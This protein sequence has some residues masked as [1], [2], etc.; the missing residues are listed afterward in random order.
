MV[1]YPRTTNQQPTQTHAPCFEASTCTIFCNKKSNSPSIQPLLMIHASPNC[2]IHTSMEKLDFG[3]PEITCELRQDLDTWIATPQ[4]SSLITAYV[5]RLP[6]LPMVHAAV[7]PVSVGLPWTRSK[8]IH[9]GKP[10]WSHQTVTVI[11]RYQAR[12]VSGKARS[13]VERKWPWFMIK[14]SEIDSWFKQYAAHLIM[15]FCQQW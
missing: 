15:L 9:Q 7:L 8:Q 4:R 5:C 11:S 3:Q 2:L 12:I 10:G 13:I 14:R 1:T 6:C